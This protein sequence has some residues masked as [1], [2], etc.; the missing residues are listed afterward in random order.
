MKHLQSALFAL[1][2]LAIGIGLGL[3][4]GN[5]IQHYRNGVTDTGGIVGG[6]DA[7]GLRGF[8]FPADAPMAGMDSSPALH[9]TAVAM[10]YLENGERLAAAVK[11]AHGRGLKVIL[12][13]PTTFAEA[14]PYPQPLAEI[15]SAAEAAKVD[16]LCMSWLNSDPD[17][18][19]FGAE[20]AEVR[21]HFTG[22]V[23]LGATPDILPGIEFL[24]EVD[25]VGAIVPAALPVPKKAGL[26]VHDFRTAWACYLDSFESISNRYGKKTVVLDTS[27]PGKNQAERAE[28]LVM[29]TKGRDGIGGVF[30]RYSPG[31]DAK[32][33]ER[34][35]M[36]WI[37]ATPAAT[38]EV[39][40]P[41]DASE[42]DQ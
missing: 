40:E 42:T 24:D 6:G 8:Y 30:L 38:K 36:L 39:A 1:V 4:I 28:A 20:I 16:I 33:L 32:L 37:T 27:A 21:K 34:L 22:Q 10:E 29:E 19:K 11:R 41:D 17:P 9:A 31:A 13:P 14:D 26:N 15:A 23:M 3:G 25:L 7:P 5:A 18:A 12:L 2:C 35:G